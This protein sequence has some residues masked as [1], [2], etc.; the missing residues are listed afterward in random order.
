[1]I[2]VFIGQAVA[3]NIRASGD[4]ANAMHGTFA[5]ERAPVQR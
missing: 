2:R 4:V 3:E 1:M 5:A